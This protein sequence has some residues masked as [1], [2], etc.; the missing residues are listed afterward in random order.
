MA[1]GDTPADAVAVF[2]QLPD[3]ACLPPLRVRA[4]AVESRDFLRFRNGLQFKPRRPYENRMQDLVLFEKTDGGRVVFVGC[5]PREPVLVFER[6]GST[7]ID[8]TRQYLPQA[9]GRSRF[10]PRLYPHYQYL[11]EDGSIA[12]SDALAPSDF[13]RSADGVVSYS[14]QLRWNGVAF[15]RTAEEVER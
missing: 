11:P 6:A 1:S 4:K 7:W 13:G 8:R 14:H 2:R 15:E 12:V 3:M 9:A 5:T 10:Y